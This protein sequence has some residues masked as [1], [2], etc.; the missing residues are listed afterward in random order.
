[1]VKNQ[2]TSDSLFFLA[3]KIFLDWIG[4][5]VK[6]WELVKPRKGR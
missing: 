5:F 3:N 6:S 2:F 4:T 1:M